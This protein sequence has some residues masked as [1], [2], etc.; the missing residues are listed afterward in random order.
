MAKVALPLYPQ[1]GTEPNGY[2]IPPRWVPRGYLQQMFGPGVD[3]AIEQYTCPDRELLAV[4]Q[5]FRRSTGSS[6]A[7]RSRKDPKIYEATLRGQKNHDVQR[8]RDCL[9]PGR[10]RNF[11]HDRWKNQYTSGQASTRTRYD[12]NK[13]KPFNR[14]A[15]FKPFKPFRR[16]ESWNL[17]IPPPPQSRGR[18]R[19]GLNGLND[20]NGLNH[21]R[22]EVANESRRNEFQSKG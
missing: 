16:F 10:Q 11:P 13:F 3:D 5:L 19:R 17:R 9:R 22:N 18:I 20:W 2:Y 15:P 12:R 7:T 8:H 1:F 14:G 4:L 21:C 6:S